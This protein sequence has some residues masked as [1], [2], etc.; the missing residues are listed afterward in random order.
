VK[1]EF[2]PFA[3]YP[4]YGCIFKDVKGNYKLKIVEKYLTY[5]TI[6]IYTIDK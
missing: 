5:R 6:A 1:V 2:R 4:I 3:I